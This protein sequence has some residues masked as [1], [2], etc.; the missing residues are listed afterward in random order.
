MVINIWRYDDARQKARTPKRVEDLAFATAL[1]RARYILD[2]QLTPQDE[3]VMKQLKSISAYPN[4]P[5]GNPNRV[6]GQ[7]AYNLASSDPVGHSEEIA[8]YGAR[9]GLERFWHLAVSSREGDELTPDQ[10]EHARQVILRV[11]GVQ[12]CPSIWAVHGDTDNQHMHGLIVSFLPAEDRSVK[13]GQDWWQEACQIAA[14]IIERDFDLDPEPR[15]R[16]VADRTGVYCRISDTRVADENGTIIGR[17]EIV[18]MEKAQRE[19]KQANYALLKEFAGTEYNLEEG[20][21][22]LA[23]PRI[24]NAKNAKEMH[25]SLARVGLRYIASKSGARVIA[26]GYGPGSGKNALGQGIAANGVYANAALKKL[27]NRFEASGGYQ[28][29]DPDLPVRRFIMPRYNAYDEGKRRDYSE[30]QLAREEAKA[31]I[32]HLEKHNA[33]RYRR[34][35]DNETGPAVNE[36]RTRRKSAHREELELAKAM[37][38]ALQPR[39]AA[40][41]KQP[42]PGPT[43]ESLA[44]LWGPPPER[45]T[46]RQRSDRDQQRAAIDSRYK[47]EP[48]GAKRYFLDGQLAFIV[49]LR[50]IE[51]F[52]RKRRVQ[53]DAAKLA[54][55]LFAKVRIAARHAMRTRFARIAEEL[56]IPIGEPMM[57]KVGKAH[58]ER[59]ETQSLPGIVASANNYEA[60]LVERQRLRREEQLLRRA[61]SGQNTDPASERTI[62]IHALLS[63]YDDAKQHCEKSM[64]PL[65]HRAALKKL[66][67]DIDHDTLML[68]SSRYAQ[69]HGGYTYRF[70]D[71]PVLL[72]EY[73]S[74]RSVLTDLQMQI[75]LQAIDAIQRDK[76]RWIAAAIASGNASVED[77]RFKMADPATAWAQNFWQ[78]QGRD[79][80]MLRLIGVARAR[81]ELFP[82][83]PDER[84]GNRALASIKNK[85]SPI[86][87][88][89]KAMRHAHEAR[90]YGPNGRTSAKAVE[91]SPHSQTKSAARETSG[92][93]PALQKGAGLAP[94]PTKSVRSTVRPHPI[95][96]DRDAQR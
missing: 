84:P 6:L 57:E 63:E 64:Q 8:I 30:T 65:P 95:N 79:P 89:I 45:T 96:H 9:A 23:K 56:N 55:L 5:K 37:S 28:P 41:Q 53:I 94:E 60:T 78:A 50:T 32:D 49:R 74:D 76:R 15:H 1:S 93:E 73:A 70:L 31:L 69:S 71:D 81:P 83:D 85:N 72:R 20:I 12:D 33:D 58:R 18:A 54:G 52:M 2:I 22:L 91:L 3:A 48:D 11:L 44:L 47:I 67:N 39:A 92:P 25:E 77:G 17:A 42:S 24:E 27:S 62:D 19:W 86:V 75:N 51:I 7:R 36:E 13:F 68:S 61:T 82:F 87:L 21:R 35:R 59:L 38:A 66:E 10:L 43:E 40:S 26:N 29:A 14:A 90:F 34:E 80:K 4:D 16:L 46:R 88:R